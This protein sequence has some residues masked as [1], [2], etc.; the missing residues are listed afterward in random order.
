[1]AESI[2]SFIA[3]AIEDP[4][5]VLEQ[6][7]YGEPTVRH[8]TRAVMSILQVMYGPD[9]KGFYAGTPA[10]RALMDN[11]GLR[12]QVETLVQDV[13]MWRRRAS[14]SEGGE[15]AARLAAERVGR[16]ENLLALAARQGQ[17]PT[18]L[19]EQIGEAMPDLAKMEV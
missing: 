10:T 5:S 4:G 16:L 13:D 2:E 6:E 15:K 9:S 19:L 11:A 18:W 12:T 7:H 14:A 3:R 1:M 8:A 17:L